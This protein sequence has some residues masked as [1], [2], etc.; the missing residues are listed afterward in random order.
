MQAGSEQAF[1]T[2]YRYYSPRLYINIL[3]IVKDPLL[4]EEIIQELFVKVWQKK[5]A[6]STVENFGGYIYRIAQN[7]IHDFFKKLKKDRQLM[8]RFRFF[9]GEYYEHIE[10]ALHQQQSA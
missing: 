7:L 8:E 4:A 5:E 10:E 9:A 3:T 2:L 6:Y 1:T